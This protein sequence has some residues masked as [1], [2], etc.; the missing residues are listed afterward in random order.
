LVLKTVFVSFLA[1]LVTNPKVVPLFFRES[2]FSFGAA[3]FDETRSI[4]EQQF[5]SAFINLILT[6][7]I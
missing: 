2:G 4:G 3:R 5:C 1:L 6:I 7:D